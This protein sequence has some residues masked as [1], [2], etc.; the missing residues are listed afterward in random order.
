MQS[1]LITTEALAYNMAYPERWKS[2]AHQK[3]TTGSRNDSPQL[4]P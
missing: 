3:E 2:Y 4:R 1:K